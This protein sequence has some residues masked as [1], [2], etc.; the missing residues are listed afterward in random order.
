[1][2]IC[3]GRFC[4]LGGAELYAKLRLGCSSARQIGMNW[5]DPAKVRANLG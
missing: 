5:D 4:E 3:V 2:R 1:M